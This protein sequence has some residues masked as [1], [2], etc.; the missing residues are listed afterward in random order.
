[1]SS[2]DRPGVREPAECPWCHSLNVHPL[3]VSAQDPVLQCLDCHEKWVQWRKCRG[4]SLRKSSE[5]A[6]LK[7]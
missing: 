7:R 6:A 1:M 4:L 2:A 5:E 3:P